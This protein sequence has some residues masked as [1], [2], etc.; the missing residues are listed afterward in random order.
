M[1]CT[2]GISLDKD[3]AHCSNEIDTIE[4]K[5]NEYSRKIRDLAEPKYTIR[6][7]LTILRDHPCLTVMQHKDKRLFS[8][9]ER[10]PTIDET[11]EL[12]MK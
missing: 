8:I 11:I 4:D 10:V 3:C 2:H 5:L 6:E 12:I 7:V 1:R 9:T